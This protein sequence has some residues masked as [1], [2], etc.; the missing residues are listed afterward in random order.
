M[1]FHHSSGL[2]VRFLSF[3]DTIFAGNLRYYK[4]IHAAFFEESVAKSSR[5]PPVV[6]G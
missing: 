3:L 2:P 4:D 6:F 5:V 1:L